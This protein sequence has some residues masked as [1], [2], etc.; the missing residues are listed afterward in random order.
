M[1]F[2]QQGGSIK[3]KFCV[4]RGDGGEEGNAQG[5]E[6]RGEG[7]KKRKGHFMRERIRGK[8]E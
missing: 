3:S 1:T 8:R 6:Q 5:S 2:I 4:E 7:G